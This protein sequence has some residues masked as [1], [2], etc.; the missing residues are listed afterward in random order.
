MRDLTSGTTTAMS[1]ENESTA[2]SATRPTGLIFAKCETG[3]R[4]VPEKL[5]GVWRRKSIVFEDGTLDDTT[6]VLWVQT[7]SGVADLR[8]P[9]DRAIRSATS[10]AACREDELRM[11]AAQDCFAAKTLFDPSAKPYETALWPPALDVLR[12]QPSI[13]FPEDGWLEWHDAGATMIERAP[14]GA[15]EEDWRLCETP[16]LAAHLTR[17]DGGLVEAIY[18]VGN[19]VAYVRGEPRPPG[20]SNLLELAGDDVEHLRALLDCEFSYGLREPDGTWR[21][22]LSTLPWR[23]GETLAVEWIR[24][25]S[26]AAAAVRDPAGHAWTLETLWR[27]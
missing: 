12:F 7:A 4:T 22:E 17:R 23:E 5:I 2:A 24:D 11:L 14:S 19:H 1:G 27:G 21:I 20:A 8:I 9:A 16:D 25:L 10:L 26:G 6:R 15:Y 3:Y 18:L 13:T